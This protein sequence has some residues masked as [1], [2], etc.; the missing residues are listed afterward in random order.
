MELSEQRRS[1]ILQRKDYLYLNDKDASIPLTVDIKRADSIT[2]ER[3]ELV[4][5][6]ERVH[7]YRFVDA[8]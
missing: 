2:G 5:Q 3:V 8:S 4:L 6:L 7:T 1:N